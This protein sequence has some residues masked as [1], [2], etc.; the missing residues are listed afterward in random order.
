MLTEETRVMVWPIYRVKPNPENPRVIR[1]E[2]FD[3]LVKSLKDFPD[4]ASVRPIVINQDNIILGGN[5]RLRAMK[6]AGWSEC[7]VIQVHWD[8]ARQR[9]FIIKDN[10]GFGEW[11]WE[12]LAN[13]W[14]AAELNDWGL[15]VPEYD[16]ASVEEEKP[17]VDA[18]SGTSLI[19]QFNSEEEAQRSH[20]L[21]AQALSGFGI[22]A[23]ISQR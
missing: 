19:I 2:Q 14:D 15:N 21:I 1:D 10:V 6:D 9:E 7:P 3:K 16:E 12:A 20:S 8:D 13:D 17:D 5:M 22:P 11:D 18:N 23:K 4:M